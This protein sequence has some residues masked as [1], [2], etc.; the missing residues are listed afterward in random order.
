MPATVLRRAVCELDAATR[1]LHC[2]ERQGERATCPTEVELRIEGSD[3]PARA[4]VT[5]V[6]PINGFECECEF[7]GN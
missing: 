5:C 3:A 2:E 6:G 1:T 4:P 7:T